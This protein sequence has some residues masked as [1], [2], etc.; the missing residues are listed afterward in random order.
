MKKTMTFLLLAALAAGQLHAQT[1]EGKVVGVSDGDTLTL[2]VDKRPVKVRL[3]NIDAPETGKGKNNPGMPF[4]Q[5]AK[6]ALSR[7]AFGKVAT[8]QCPEKDRYE[9]LVCE[10]FVD[11]KN[12]NLQQVNQGMAWVYEQYAKNPAYYQAQQQAQAKKLGLWADS[13]PQKPWEWRK[14]QRKHDHS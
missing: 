10:V 11:G 5:A 7:A 1:L 6:E 2:L 14:A 9:R 4:G 13:N 12:I 3:A 8:A